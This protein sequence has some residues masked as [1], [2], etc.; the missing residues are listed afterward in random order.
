MGVGSNEREYTVSEIWIC[1][2]NSNIF[3]LISLLNPAINAVAAIMTATL[4]ATATTA[5]RMMIREKFCFPE[6]AM[7]RAMKN[8][9][10]K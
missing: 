2:Q 8:G 5:M 4:S 9:R 3:R 10:F 7:R 1:P 6:K